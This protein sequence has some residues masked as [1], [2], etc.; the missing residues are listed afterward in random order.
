[1]VKRAKKTHSGRRKPCVSV[2]RSPLPVLQ[3]RESDVVLID[4]LLYR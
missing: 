4:Y 2:T 1:M 3:G